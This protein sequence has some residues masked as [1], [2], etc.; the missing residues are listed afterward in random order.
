MFLPVEEQLGLIREG[1]DEVVPE[2]ELVEKLK[3]SRDTS[4]PLIVKQGFDPTRPDLHVG[5]GVSIHKLRT[6]QELGHRVVFVM[7]TYTALIGD[8][9]GR[10]ETRPVLTEEEIEDNLVTYQDQVFRILDPETTEIRRNGDWLAPLRLRD[11]L[12][13]TG[14]YTVAR[15]LERDDFGRRYA[16]GRP[17]SISEFLY[18]MMQAYDSVELGADVELGGTDQ[19]FNLLLGRTLQ[20]RAGQ[21]P[22]VCL[23]MPLLRGTDGQRKM[24]KTYDNY[25]GIAMEPAEIFGRAMS[26]PDD[27]LPEWL[28]LL[29]SARGPALA[30]KIEEA[31]ADPLETKRWLAGDLVRR[32]HDDDA[33]LAARDSFDRLHRDRLAPELDEL[34]VVEIV[35]DDDG[36]GIW[37]PYIL[38]DAGLASSS[39]EAVRLVRQGAVRVDGET[40]ED[41]DAKLGGG[42]YLIQRGKRRFARVR[43]P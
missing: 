8:P 12:R 26:I 32:Y 36:S 33:A 34:P 5:H 11:I 16:E 25:I 22:Q 2:N 42:E 4:T 30:G 31:A 23:I 35:R 14:Q 15:M 17:I 21:E 39:S 13:L 6:F 1:A 9:S 18:P 29:S 43:I 19:K 40:V 41:R 7:G 24:S 3:R 28:T 37:V 27:L 20:E 10:D 38:I